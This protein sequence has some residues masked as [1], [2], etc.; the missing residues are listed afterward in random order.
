MIEKP[1]VGPASC[2]KQAARLRLAPNWSSLRFSGR[3]TES[4]LPAISAAGMSIH[5]APGRLTGDGPCGDPGEKARRAQHLLKLITME[6][7][8]AHAYS[9]R[10]LLALGEAQTD[11]GCTRRRTT[12]LPPSGSG[13]PTRLN[14]DVGSLLW[15]AQRA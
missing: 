11:A 7:E 5:L 4:L 8:D 1:P 2:G 12:C 15:L 10:L 14:R 9:P 3:A 13:Q 6:A